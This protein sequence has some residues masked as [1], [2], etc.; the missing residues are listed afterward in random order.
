MATIVHVQK[1]HE[2]QQRPDRHTWGNI[3][4]QGIFFWETNLNVLF[5]LCRSFH[6]YT[7]STSLFPVKKNR[8]RL[9]A[10]LNRLERD[11]GGSIVFRRTESLN[12]FECL[13]ANF[14]KCCGFSGSEFGWVKGVAMMHS[15]VWEHHRFVWNRLRVPFALA[16][17]SGCLT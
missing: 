4:A 9:V 13:P 16:D 10:L 14:R 7:A 5:S 2:S 1:R 3:K 12:E 15:V 6:D 17:T 11:L 8:S